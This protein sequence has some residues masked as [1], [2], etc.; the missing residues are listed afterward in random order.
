MKKTE[1]LL[2]HFWVITYI[3]SGF[4][5]YEGKRNLLVQFWAKNNITSEFD[6]YEKKNKKKQKLD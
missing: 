4:R 2:T 6:F 3:A 5:F 1:T